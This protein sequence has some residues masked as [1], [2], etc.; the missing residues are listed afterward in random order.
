MFK[1]I[2]FPV[3]MNEYS[4]QII[5]CIG[6]L[7]KNGTEE[8]LL[9][10]V[11]SVSELAKGN[12][13]QAQDEAMLNKWKGV[14]EDG[15]IRTEY[16]MIKGIPWLEIVELADRSDY[17]FVMLGSHGSTFLDKMFLGSVTEN[18]V[19]HTHKPVFIF[20]LKK[21]REAAD[22]RYCVDVFRKVLY[23]TDF[24]DYSR[25]CIP[26]IENMKNSLYQELEILH[27]QDLR[28]VKYADSFRL[29]EMNRTDT[30]RLEE[31]KAHFES[32]GFGKVAF[33]LKTGYAMTEILDH[34][35]KQDCS[36]IV[37]GKKGSSDVK[38]MLLG[39]VAETIIHKSEIP[40]FLT[41]K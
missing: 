17:S 11:L 41:G 27:V 12:V 24:S 26:F 35:A 30:E 38:E 25:A 37:L 10:H 8:A 21:D 7:S 28:Q 4:E 13:S 32:K 31:L 15:G 19:H 16:R 39:G 6:G 14:L 9:F 23:A 36:I 3:I 40:V 5:N 33:Y 20:K 2:L 34:A 22:V 1:K 29:K 18:V